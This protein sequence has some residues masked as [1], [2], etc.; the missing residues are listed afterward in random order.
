MFAADSDTALLLPRL[1]TSPGQLQADLGALLSREPLL[2]AP[3]AIASDP[4]PQLTAAAENLRTAFGGHGRELRD[5]LDASVTSKFI[6][7]TMYKAATL[8]TCWQLLQ[9]WCDRAAPTVDFDEKLSRL[10]TRVLLEKTNKAGQG[11]TPQSPLCD[12]IDAFLDARAQY[13]AWLDTHSTALLHRVR[14]EARARLA[15][16]KRV[17]RLQTYDDLIDGVADALDGPRGDELVTALRKQYAIALVD[18]F[19]DT[20]P[21]QWAIFRRVFG[22]P[23]GDDAAESLSEARQQPASLFL[24]GDPKQAIYGFRG[25]DVHTYLQARETA[26]LAP[27]LERNFRSRPGVLD[28]IATL[29]AAADQ[30]HAADPAVAPPF[31]DDRIRF[32]PMQAGGQRSDDDFLRDGTAAPALTVRVIDDPDDLSTSKISADRSRALATLA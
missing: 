6:N 7:A 29:Y 23:S 31:V 32:H 19:Q 24:I 25:G 28:A 26:A 10:G 15:E 18:E 12:A 4:L 17:R 8:D 5:A 3:Q 21:R 22:Q 9:R 14:T 11:R 2:P 16:L 27:P 1:W 13:E 30:A 20:D